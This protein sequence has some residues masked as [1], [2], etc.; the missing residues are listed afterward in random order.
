MIDAEVL[1]LRPEQ[2]K[3]TVNMT[4][5]LQFEVQPPTPA[6]VVPIPKEELRVVNTDS[7][8]Q[9]EKDLVPLLLLRER[10]CGFILISWK[11]S[12]GLLLPA[13]SL[14]GKQKLHLAI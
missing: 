11:A 10:S 4:S 8:H 1:K 2:K 7:H 5:F 13:E 12:N 14:G 6:R 3:V 9:L